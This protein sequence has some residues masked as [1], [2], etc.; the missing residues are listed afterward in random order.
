MENS[1]ATSTKPGVKILSTLALM[2]AMRALSMQYE[3]QTGTAV[4]ADFAPTN[5]LLNRIASGELADVAILTSEAINHLVDTGVLVRGSQVDLALS[6]VGIAVRAGAPQPEINSVDSLK[7]ALLKA[8]SIAYSKIGASGVFFAD[9]IRRLGI[10]DEINAKARIIPSGFTAELV[11]SGEVELAIQ[12]VSELMV[13]PGV[14]VAAR[15]PSEVQSSTMFSAGVL[16]C[17]NQLKSATRLLEVLS[18]RECAPILRASG[19]DP[20]ERA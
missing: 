16:S 12:Q 18:S 14:E 15:L 8:E 17:S 13:V 6:S 7:S 3:Q 11:A 19:L 5:A 9:L 2:K 10:A 20:L 4:I 1:H